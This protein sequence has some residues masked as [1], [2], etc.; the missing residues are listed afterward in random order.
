[1]NAQ[2]EQKQFQ[3]MTLLALE[4]FSVSCI[5]VPEELVEVA[6]EPVE[7]ADEPSNVIQS[8]F[9]R[10]QQANITDKL[11]SELCTA[12]SE[13]KEKCHG[14]ILQDCSVC[15]GALYQH[16]GLWVPANDELILELV[17]EVHVPPS[18]RHKG[19]NQTVKLI[20]CYYYWPSMRKTVKQY[21]QNCYECKRLKS[22]KDQKNRLLNP[23][24]IPKQRWLD[25]SM[26]F[27]TGLPMTKDGKNAILNVMDRLPKE[28]HYLTCTSDD[29]GTTTEE[30]LKMLIYWVYQLHG[31]P[32][33]ITSDR[34]PQFV[35]TMWKS[36]CKRMGIQV[37][38]LTA[39]HPETDRQTKQAN[40]DVETF[41]QAYTNE[42][43]DDWDTWLPM[44]ELAD[45]NADSAA[46]T[47]SP[48][49]MNHR[50]HLQMSFGPDPTLYEAT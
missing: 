36:F 35:S 37:N 2:D 13:G 23:L 17:Q 9:E 16:E 11:C 20:K 28:R 7:V 42:N 3:Q 30:T 14:I 5:D 1:M 22:S 45:N 46:T 40:Q 24:P 49:F 6:E 18:D 34:G 41:L 44:A 29:N 48:F 43:Q 26:D 12:E 15:E 33:S 38:L 27:I 21:I 19:I 31:M 47:L 8:R 10:I 32:A 25:I 39:F 50:F 4:K